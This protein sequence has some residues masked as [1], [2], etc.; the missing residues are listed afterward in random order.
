MQNYKR[1]RATSRFIVKEQKKTPCRSICSKLNSKTTSRK[2][3][4]AIRKIKGKRGSSS[5]GHLHEN[6]N[7][8]TDT[9]PNRQFV[10][11]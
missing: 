8:I 10:G 3:W 6:G 11:I 4:K 9:K 2:V 5:V 7:L 1:L